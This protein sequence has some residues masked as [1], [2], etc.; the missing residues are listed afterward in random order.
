MAQVTL[1]VSFEM[2]LLNHL[3]WGDNVGDSLMKTWESLV[4]WRE[5][6]SATAPHQKKKKKG[7]KMTRN[8][9]PGRK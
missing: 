6:V 2:E 5:T 4:Y 8:D 3:G 7:K 1:F 9:M